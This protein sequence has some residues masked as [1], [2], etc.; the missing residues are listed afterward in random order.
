MIQ[1]WCEDE[2]RVG[3][4]G[5]IC[6]H[7]YERGVRPPGTADQR[8]DSL[9]LFAACRPGT[10]EAFA[11]AL[12]RATTEAMVVFLAAF[13]QQLAPGVH[14]VLLLDQ[15]GWHLT[16]KLMVPD[17]ITLLPLPACSPELGAHRDQESRW[18]LMNPVERVWLYLRERFLS[19]RL[20]RDHAAVLDA[21][22]TAWIRLVQETGRLASLTGYPYLM[23]SGFR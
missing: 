10:D 4:K 23:Q 12:P 21:T 13:A 16:P 7:W 2:A 17:T 15:A 11:L 20:H 19:H 3:Q 14:A 22:C 5:R 9:Y 6:H 18:G 1:L 8:Y